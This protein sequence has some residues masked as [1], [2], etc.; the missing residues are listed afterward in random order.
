VFGIVPAWPG[1]QQALADET[2]GLDVGRLVHGEQRM[3]FHRPLRAGD[4][5][6]SVGT[7]ASIDER[8]ANEI[9]VL[10]FETRDAEDALVVEQE[11]VVVSRGTAP[12]G[13][14]ASGGG[15]KRSGA[16]P[17]EEAPAPAAEREV[18]LAD[19]LPVRYARASGDD[20]RIH[21]DDAFAREMGLPGVIVQGMCLLAISVGAVIDELAGGDPGRVRGIRA[22]FA[23]PLRPGDAYTTQIWPAPEGARFAGVGPEGPALR[24]GVVELGP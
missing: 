9:F 5:L 24:D 4:E 2:L 17:A 7:L 8:G 16:R 13:A 11:V 21:I 23:R 12:G 22:R 19:D 20:N 10:A 15:S 3:T 18:T 1:V 6:R 14:A